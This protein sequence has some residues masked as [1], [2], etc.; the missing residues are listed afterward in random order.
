MY[1]GLLQ[2]LGRLGFAPVT[3]F[4]PINRSLARKPFANP[5]GVH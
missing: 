4:A 1:A 3:K 2:V 5:G